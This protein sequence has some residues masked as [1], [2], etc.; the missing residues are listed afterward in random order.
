MLS[1]AVSSQFVVM[2]LNTQ[3]SLKAWL[4]LD[5]RRDDIVS[6]RDIVKRK[7]F[8]TSDIARFIWV[9]DLQG[10]WGEWDFGC[11]IQYW[12]MQPYN[13]TEWM[14]YHPIPH[15]LSFQ[16]MNKIE[17]ILGRIPS[18]N[19]YFYHNAKNHMGVK[20]LP[21]TLAY[22]SRI[23]GTIDFERYAPVVAYA[24]PNETLIHLGMWVEQWSYLS[25]YAKRGGMLLKK[26]NA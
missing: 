21:D 11:I 17:L 24:G 16:W 1:V 26:R 13:E 9:K 15:H 23:V 3:I 4:G 19:T 8:V 2:F 5:D 14:T 22:R 10:N 25:N 12:A 18:N 6:T 20:I 7:Q